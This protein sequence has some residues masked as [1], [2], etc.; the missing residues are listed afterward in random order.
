MMFNESTIC[1]HI[2]TTSPIP[3]C[4]EWGYTKVQIYNFLTFPKTHLGLPRGLYRKSMYIHL[5]N[6]ELLLGIV[7]ETISKIASS[8]RKGLEQLRQARQKTRSNLPVPPP[9]SPDTLTHWLGWCLTNH[10]QT[11]LQDSKKGALT[12]YYSKIKA[13]LF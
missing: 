3:W 2:I 6:I 9:A 4:L 10:K 12:G 13:N 11:L 7:L 5:I 8:L 1:P